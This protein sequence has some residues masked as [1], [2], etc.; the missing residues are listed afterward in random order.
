M[1]I[2]RI[3][4]DK[5]NPGQNFLKIAAIIVALAGVIGSIYFLFNAGSKQSSVVLLGLFTGWILSPFIGLFIFTKI[6]NRWSISAR[7]LFYG[8]MIILPIVSVIAYS[9]AFNTS[10]TKNA[11][12]FLIVPLIS[13]FLIVTVFLVARKI[14]NNRSNA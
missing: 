6:S 2:K 9:G 12:I 7:S 3:M 13:W 10:K 1:P 5:K 8:L 11:F 4:T 14:S